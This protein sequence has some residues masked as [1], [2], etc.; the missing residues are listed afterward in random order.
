MWWCADKS[1]PGYPTSENRPP[2]RHPASASLVSGDGKGRGKGG[3][4]MGNKFIPFSMATLYAL[5]RRRDSLH[6]CTGIHAAVLCT[7]G[8]LTCARWR[9]DCVDEWRQIVG[10]LDSTYDLMMYPCDG[11]IP[12]DGFNWAGEGGPEHTSEN[13]ITKE[14]KTE[15][16]ASERSC[17]GGKRRYR[18]IML[19][20]PWESAKT[21]ANQLIQLRQDMGLTP[22]TCLTLHQGVTARYWRVQHVGAA[23]VSTIEAIAHVAWE[24]VY[25][26]SDRCDGTVRKTEMEVDGNPQGSS[27]DE[28]SNAIQAAD[29][30]RKTLL[31]LFNLQR[32]R[33]FASMKEGGRVPL[34]MALS[35][36]GGFS[37][38]WDGY[39]ARHS[40][41]TS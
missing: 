11:A 12:A 24:A 16:D 1:R 15:G 13:E 20:G 33:V 39:L 38:F 10:S 28:E 35:H 6:K 37:T 19:E 2:L 31:T 14:N 40:I 18:L 30:C 8:T 29:K 32:Y 41:N 3:G 34:A 4:G 22:L 26:T 36:S 27:P 7:E 9:K 25:A 23:A 21:M 17:H 5:Q